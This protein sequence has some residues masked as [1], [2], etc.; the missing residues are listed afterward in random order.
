MSARMQRCVHSSRKQ[1]RSGSQAQQE[2]LGPGPRTLEAPTASGQDVA[3]LPLSSPEP[4]P[5]WFPWED[6]AARAG[7]RP[8]GKPVAILP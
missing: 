6:R 8:S 7:W 5:L 2:G 1:Q 4:R 3:L